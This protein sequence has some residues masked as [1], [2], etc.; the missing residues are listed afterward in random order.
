MA[1]EIDDQPIEKGIDA[2]STLNSSI[3]VREETQDFTFLSDTR[4]GLEKPKT[5]IKSAEINDFSREYIAKVENEVAEISN[6][7]IVRR[8]LVL[9]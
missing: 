6:S 2:L 5:D 9:Y 8:L 1:N 7:A 4:V 3:C